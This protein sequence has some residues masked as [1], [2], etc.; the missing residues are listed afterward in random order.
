MF[1]L[2]KGKGD[3]AQK[4][5]LEGKLIKDKALARQMR[6]EF[7]LKSN[8]Q[9]KAMR[10]GMSAQEMD[11]ASALV[12]GYLCAAMIVDKVSQSK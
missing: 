4:Y 6:D 8:E 12:K 7:N 5:E 2:G 9:K 10:A 1:D 11:T 3:A